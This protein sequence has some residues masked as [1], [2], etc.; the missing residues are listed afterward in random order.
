MG[1]AGMK[2]SAR[3]SGDTILRSGRRLVSKRIRLTSMAIVDTQE[4]KVELID[5][6]KHEREIKLGESKKHINGTYQVKGTDHEEPREIKENGHRTDEQD[7]EI[8]LGESKKTSLVDD[9]LDGGDKVSR[10]KQFGAVYTRKRKRTI[11]G[12]SSLKN[13]SLEEKCGSDKM[14]KNKYFKKRVRTNLVSGIFNSNLGFNGKD[15]LSKGPVIF[16][17]TCS[18]RS[19]GFSCSVSSVLRYMRKVKV[20]SWRQFSS[21]LLSELTLSIYSSIGI[22]SSQ[23]TTCRMGHGF[24]KVFGSVLSIPLFTV[25]FISLP[26]CFL[27]MH[28]SLLL[29]FAFLSYALISHPVV[30]NAMDDDIKVPSVVTELHH[31]SKYMLVT[32]PRSSRKRVPRV[33]LFKKWQ[34]HVDN[35]IVPVPGV[36]EVAGYEQE[37]Y[38]PFRLPDIYI[39]SKSDEVSRTLQKS[40]PIYDMESADEEWLK[41]F[42]KEQFGANDCVLE[43]TFEKVID[44]FERGSY[45]SSIDYSNATSAINRCVGLASK[46]VLEALYRYWMT[47]RKKK[48]SPLVRV[49]Q[50]YPRKR[51]RKHATNIVLRKKRS[52]RR[53]KSQLHAGKHVGFLKAMLMM[54]E[55]KTLEEA[56]NAYMK[57][58]ETQEDVRRSEMAAIV[59]RQEAQAL[60]ETADLA[61]YRATMALRIAEARAATTGFSL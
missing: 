11:P 27:Y 18:D 48:R 51:V 42:N 16:F 33:S 17:G 28:S 49:F 52:L 5:H 45:C 20:F 8:K 32:K 14:F 36:R 37:E 1:S 13:N 41:K 56:A 21:F 4:N 43:D 35:N 25:D 23:D 40:Y 55:Q 59:K 44:A 34:T 38:V 39:S 31:F 46:D 10:T 53:R 61:T 19:N 58:H 50:C 9:N 15:V 26:F 54:N 29:K 47:K 24:L 7:D 60:M 6:E 22:R 3:V 2:R 30:E 57:V 12:D